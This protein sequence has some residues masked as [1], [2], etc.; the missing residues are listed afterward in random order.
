MHDSKEINRATLVPAELLEAL[1]SLNKYSLQL[2][3]FRRH[4]KSPNKKSPTLEKS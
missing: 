3:L 4:E 2:Y 1:T